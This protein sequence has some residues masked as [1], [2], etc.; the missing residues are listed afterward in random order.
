MV[1]FMGFWTWGAHMFR[2]YSRNEDEIGGLTNYKK[3]Y[4]NICNE[5]ITVELPS[6]ALGKVV[7]V[8]LPPNNVNVKVKVPC[9]PIG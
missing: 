5:G 1:I 8:T 4:E 3:T 6:G 2:K 9:A 7:G